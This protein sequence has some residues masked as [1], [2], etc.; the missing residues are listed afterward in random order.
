MTGPGRSRRGFVPAL[1][2]DALTPLYDPLVALTTR[3]ATFKRRLLGQAAVREALAVLDLGCGTG[4]LATRIARACPEANVTALDGDER[5]LARARR[6]A[7]AAGVEVRFDLGMAQELPYPDAAFDRVVSSL[8]FHHLNGPQKRQVVGEV[9]RVLKPGGEFHV[10]DWHRPQDPL[11]R[12]LF[13]P[14]R[15]IDG[16]AHTA[17]NVKGRLP[18]I[19][20]QAGFVRTRVESRMRTVIGTLGLFSAVKPHPATPPRSGSTS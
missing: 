20:E 16:F 14:V 3:E 7:E 5:M 12:L 19:F 11:M 10:A 9:F 17:D 6:K 1:G 18:G 15:V 13:L 8:F 4:T 2:I